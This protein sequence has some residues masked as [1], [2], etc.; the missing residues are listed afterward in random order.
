[1]KEQIKTMRFEAEQ[2]KADAKEE[3]E[4]ELFN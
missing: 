1:M 2:L 4:K 3:F